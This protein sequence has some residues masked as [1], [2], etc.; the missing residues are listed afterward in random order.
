[1]M[2]DGGR[3]NGQQI[4][5][6]NWVVESTRASAPPAANSSPMGYG[7]QW[8][9]PVNAKD[10]F[11]AIGIYGQYIYVNRPSRVVIVKTSAHRDFDNDGAGAA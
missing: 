3:A 4:I 8:W 6:E 5:P 7:Y 11:Y 9:V 10:E 2:L 1:M